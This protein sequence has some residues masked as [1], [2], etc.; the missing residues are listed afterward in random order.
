MGRPVGHS[1]GGLLGPEGRLKGRCH[2]ITYDSIPSAGER[3]KSKAPTLGLQETL[4]VRPANTEMIAD[5]WDFRS[6]WL[7]PLLRDHCATICLRGRDQKRVGYRLT[8]RLR[9]SGNQLLE[10]RYSENLGNEE[11]LCRCGRLEN[12]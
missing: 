9:L 8:N 6:V 5:I 3:S 1:V 10:V 7:P 4:E 11:G 2:L 12:R